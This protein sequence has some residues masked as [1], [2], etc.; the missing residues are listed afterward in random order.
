[1]ADTHE[2][3][4]RLLLRFDE[5]AKTL[6]IGRST[7]YNLVARGEIGADFPTIWAALEAQAKGDNI[8]SARSESD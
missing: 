6:G 7:V 8:D 2:R 3:A 1:M 4:P 5:A